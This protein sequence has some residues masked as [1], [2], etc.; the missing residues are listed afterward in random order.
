MVQ[1]LLKKDS[2]F[3]YYIKEWIYHT[4]LIVVIA[5]DEGFMVYEEID[6]I[7]NFT[8]NFCSIDADDEEFV[9]HK[10]H[11][12]TILRFILT[13]FYIIILILIM[14]IF[15]RM[16]YNI[17]LVDYLEFFYT[18]FWYCYIIYTVI[19]YYLFLTKDAEIQD[20]LNVDVELYLDAIDYIFFITRMII[21]YVI[22]IYFYKKFMIKHPEPRLYIYIYVYILVFFIVPLDIITLEVYLSNFYI[23]EYYLFFHNYLFK[24]K[25]LDSNQRC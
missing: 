13:L 14:N 15:K 23:I 9:L 22:L 6:P 24:W 1:K 18:F 8:L 20:T 25:K 10:I 21:L 3:I 12:Y 4:V 2:L 7:I 16:K 17:V 5:F 11:D 19:Y